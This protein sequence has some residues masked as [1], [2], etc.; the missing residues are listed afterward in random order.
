MPSPRKAARVVLGF[1][2]CSTI[3]ADYWEYSRQY[4]ANPAIWMDVVHGTAGAPQQY[5]IGVAWLADLLRRHGHMGLRHGFTLIDLVCAAAAVFM[6][7]SLL[8]RSRAYRAASATARWFGA[9]A[10]VFLVQYY[11]AWITWYQRPETMASALVLAATLWLL[12]VRLPGAR[13]ASMAV[14]SGAMLLLAGVQGFIRPDVVFALHLGVLLVCLTKTGDGFALGRRAQAATSVVAVLL[15]G[16]I[17]YALMHRVYPHAGYGTTPVFELALN[18]TQPMR[19]APF[20][21]FMLPWAW[22]VTLLARRRWR[23]DA[24]GA[25]LV[26]GSAI[27]V[28]LWLVVGCMDEV[29]IFMPFAVALVPV[30]CACAMERLPGAKDAVL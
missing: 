21:L 27:Y 8:E 17:Q 2:V 15:A 22:L 9:A 19:W 23:A 11:F 4:H 13:G 20:G 12:T 28:A 25:A 3:F 6:L 1:V 16:G 29:R 14:A 26:A 18:V 5:R 24:A 10:F 30:T 7:Y